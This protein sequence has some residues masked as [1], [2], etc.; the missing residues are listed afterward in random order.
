MD[1][2]EW[3]CK[4]TAASGRASGQQRVAVQVD[5]S[6]WPCRMALRTAPVYHKG[7]VTGQNGSQARVR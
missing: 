3:P 5:G 4:W 2:S 6:E 7:Q 1:G